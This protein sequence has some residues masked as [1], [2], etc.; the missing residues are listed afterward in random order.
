MKLT[1]QFT[2]EN[3]KGLKQLEEHVD[4]NKVYIYIYT[5]NIHEC[6]Y[7]KISLAMFQKYFARLILIFSYRDFWWLSP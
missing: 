2:I 4:N 1:P 3:K 5:S 7:T 6:M